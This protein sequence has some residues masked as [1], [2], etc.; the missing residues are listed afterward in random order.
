MISIL[1]RRR[2]EHR[3]FFDIKHLKEAADEGQRC[4]EGQDVGGRL[5]DRD[6]VHSHEG[7][8]YYQH[9]HKKYS[10]PQRGQYRGARRETE[11]LHHHLR[12]DEYRLEDE[13]R[14]LTAEGKGAYADDRRVSVAEYGDDLPREDICKDRNG[15]HAERANFY[16]EPEAL[17][18]TR[19][20]LRP[21]IVGRHG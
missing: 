14:R 5:A 13:Y 9:R 3:F 7:R 19:V 6:A 18:D 17:A 8:Q 16:R 21:V 12:D 4:K 2:I 1:D 11:L 15:D 10:L 20:L